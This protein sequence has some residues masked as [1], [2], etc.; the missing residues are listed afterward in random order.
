M[1]KRLAFVLAS[2]VG[3]AACYQADA[4]HRHHRRGGCGN[5]CGS[6]EV[7]CAQPCCRTEYKTVQKTV[8]V[9]AMF[10]ES[11]TINVT[12]CRVEQRPYSYTVM[13]REAQTRDVQCQVVVPRWEERTR[14]VNYTVCKPVYETRAVRYTVMVPYTERRQATRSVCRMVPVQMTRTVCEDRGHWEERPCETRCN[15]CCA[16]DEC[17]GY[18][19]RGRIQQVAYRRGGSGCGGCAAPC[20]ATRRVWVPNIVERQVAYTCMRPRVEQVPYEY[21]VNRCRP[22]E[23]TRNVQVCRMVSEPRSRE[24]HYRVCVPERRTVTRQVTTY[25]CVPERR[26]ATCSVRVPY[27]E[28]KEIPVRVCRM[29]PKTITCQVP[30]RHCEM[31]PA[32]NNCCM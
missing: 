26:T 19:R 32:A 5:S 6:C 15:D 8:M 30:V 18:Q 24:V 16:V 21:T 13:R 20:Q 7:A 25:R 17:G 10:T 3:L 4:G 11:R 14:T 22:E 2:A 27:T 28:Q 1:P 9:P 23:R 31:A 12:R 29:V